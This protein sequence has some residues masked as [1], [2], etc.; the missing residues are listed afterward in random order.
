MMSTYFLD[1]L[2]NRTDVKVKMDLTNYAKKLHAKAVT[3]VV[4]SCFAKTID[5]NSLKI[6]KH[7]QKKVP[8]DLAKV[9]KVFQNDIIKNK[10][11]DD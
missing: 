1:P 3:G 6:D 7:K 4:T 2:D 11:Y 9:S 8:G 10:I 5:L